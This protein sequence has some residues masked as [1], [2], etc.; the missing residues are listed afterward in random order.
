MIM[1]HGDPLGGISFTL[2]FAILAFQDDLPLLGPNCA[3]D[4]GFFSTCPPNW[5]RMAERSLP[6]KSSSPR[7]VKRWYSEA[8]STGAGVVDSMAARSVHRPSPES[9]TRPEYRSRAGCS[10]REMAVRSSSQEATTLPR[11]HTS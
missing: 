7:E 3:P 4:Y 1:T 8:L 5:K 6:A 2:A 11:R 9:E 10:S